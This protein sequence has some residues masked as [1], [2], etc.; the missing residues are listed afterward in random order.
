ML[1]VSDG[2]S[3]CADPDCALCSPCKSKTGMKAT[4]LAQAWRS[5]AGGEVSTVPAAAAT[6]SMAVAAG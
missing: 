1:A 5:D 4:A 6:P 2:S 3:V